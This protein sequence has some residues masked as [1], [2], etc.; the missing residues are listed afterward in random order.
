VLLDDASNADL[1]AAAT[2]GDSDAFGQLV[3]RH[4]G[5]ARRLAAGLVGTDDAD[6]VAQDAFV[7]AYRSLASFR[8]DSPF[9]P[10]L[11]RIVLNE[12]KNHLRK[13]GRRERRDAL[14]GRS[15]RDTGPDPGE[16]AAA[17]DERRRLDAAL[18]VLPF[19]D[20]QFLVIRYFLDYSEAETADLLGCARGT[21]KSGTSRAL[22][23]LRAHTELSG[24]G[25]RP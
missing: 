22:S 2:R 13:T 1:I 11:L 5:P 20:R 21:V 17:S 19:R 15:R 25:D 7:R 12:A 14:F 8:V 23:K 6:D 3:S 10:W 4:Q 24:L 18:A 16:L 9:R